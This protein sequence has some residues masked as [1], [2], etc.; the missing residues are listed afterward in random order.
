MKAAL[1]LAIDL[2]MELCSD[3]IGNIGSHIVMYLPKCSSGI[4]FLSYVP[5][6]CIE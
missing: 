5:I 4:C 3:F 2:E 6:V 1:L